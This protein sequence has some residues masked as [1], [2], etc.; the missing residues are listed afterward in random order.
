[1][2]Q[3]S[4]TSLLLENK[5]K[6]GRNRLKGGRNYDRVFSGLPVALRVVSLKT[7]HSRLA[8][9]TAP[10]RKF[11]RAPPQKS[12]G[13]RR[14]ASRRRALTQLRSSSFTVLTSAQD[15]EGRVIS[16]IN[17]S[18]TMLP[19]KMD[20]DRQRAFRSPHPDELHDLPLPERRPRS[21]G[22]QIG[23]VKEEILGPILRYNETVT[24]T[25]KET[26]DPPLHQSPDVT[27]HEARGAAPGGAQ[28]PRR[29]PPDLMAPAPA[30]L[31]TPPGYRT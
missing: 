25:T 9:A 14:P 1:M 18:W 21:P 26:F 12:L 31:G 13:A 24:A 19:Y 28:H 7:V 17:Y 11:N 16:S 22:G 5:G 20:P 2:G 8:L 4:P 30:P 3:D 23:H 15:S 6:K 29:P 10:L 27:E